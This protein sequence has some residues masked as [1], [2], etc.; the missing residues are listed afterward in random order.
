MSNLAGNQWDE[1]WRLL[2][3]IFWF[4]RE[5]SRRLLMNSPGH[6]RW[7]EFI[8]LSFSKGIRKYTPRGRKRTLR[9]TRDMKFLRAC[10]SDVMPLIVKE[11]KLALTL[12][13]L[14]TLSSIEQKNFY[15]N[16]SGNRGK[17]RYSKMPGHK[18][19]SK[20]DMDHLIA[21]LKSRKVVSQ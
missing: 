10:V 15:V 14:K 9:N 8:S 11:D 21:Y 5:E 2:H 4:G 1:K 17:F 12:R 13:H 16:L 20:E 6:G 18:H 3:P 7:Q 19:L